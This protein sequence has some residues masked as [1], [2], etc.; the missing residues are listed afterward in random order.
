MEPGLVSRRL[1]AR[2]R[3]QSAPACRFRAAHSRLQAERRF[4]SQTPGPHRRRAGVMYIEPPARHLLSRT[5]SVPL[6]LF[7]IHEMASETGLAFGMTLTT[8]LFTLS[9]VLI[10]FAPPANNETNLV[11]N[12]DFVSLISWAFGYFVISRPYRH[13]ERPDGGCTAARSSRPSQADH[14]QSRRHDHT[15]ARL[16][17]A[18]NG[19]VARSVEPRIESLRAWRALLLRAQSHCHPAGRRHTDHAGLHICRR[20]I[21]AEQC[22]ARR[23]EPPT[24]T[25]L[26]VPDRFG[27]Q[28]HLKPPTINA[29][30]E[31]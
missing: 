13:G 15:R 1:L 29:V 20:S 25:A 8:V 5:S 3:L 28:G 22:S 21:P 11:Y 14:T 30:A 4:R 27:A 31:V 26:R 16:L 24:S 12:K 18:P 9:T 17:R 10:D 19:R 23:I 2:R 7:L 6:L